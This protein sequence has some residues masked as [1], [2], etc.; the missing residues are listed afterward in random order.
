MSSTATRPARVPP[1]R[2]G[3]IR[4]P[5][6]SPRSA[7]PGAAAP[8]PPSSTAAG[9]AGV[10]GAVENGVR[11]AYAVIDDYMK[12]GFEAARG[13]PNP[14]SP[15]GQMS[16]SFGNPNN[17]LGSMAPLMEQWM[18]VMRVW[19]DAWTNLVPG[20]A[21]AGFPGAGFAFGQQDKPAPA[22][23][24]SSPTALTIKVTSAKPTEIIANLQPGSDGMGLR[25][26]PLAALGF[27]AAALDQV[28][29]TRENGRL[30]MA[31]V[32]PGGQPAGAYRGTVRRIADSAPM[33]D[34]LVVIS[35]PPAGN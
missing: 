22:N 7:P 5:L 14:F 11:N 9:E 6:V 35:D 32:I 3:P 17:P 16:D 13:N 28:A 12:R 31:V 24:Q 15:R 23:P 30:V 2:T 18:S 1:A 21:Q 29:F 25:A 34:M 4:N 20:M 27:S 10:C 8:P 33:G 26:D 19:V